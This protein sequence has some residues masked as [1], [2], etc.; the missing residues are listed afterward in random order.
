MDWVAVP[1]SKGYFQ[2]RD[3]A[4]LLRWQAGSLLLAPPGKPCLFTPVSSKGYGSIW[5]PLG[6]R[7]HLKTE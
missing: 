1:S 6:P 5:H 4:H 3:R 2:P 7:D